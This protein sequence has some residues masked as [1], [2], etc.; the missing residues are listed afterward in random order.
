MAETK[1]TKRKP[2]FIKVDHLLP[3]TSG[4]TSTV[5][6]VNSKMLLQKERPDKLQ[7]RQVKIAECLVGDETGVILFTAINEQ[8]IYKGSMRL[9][10]DKWGCI[11]VTEPA[12]FTLEEYNNL[13]LLE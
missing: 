2:V 4:H 5:R 3:G 1:P 7:T 10:V 13:S 11:E 6:V 9:A 8:D 12:N